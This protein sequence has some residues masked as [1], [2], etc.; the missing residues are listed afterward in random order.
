MS[1]PASTKAK[2]DFE[3]GSLSELCT[4]YAARCLRKQSALVRGLV[5]QAPANV[6][7]DMII[8]TVFSLYC[9]SAG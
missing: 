6:I 3:G 5:L 7:E 8:N 4:Y 9:S 1:R 2:I